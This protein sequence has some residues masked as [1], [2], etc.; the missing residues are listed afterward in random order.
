MTKRTHDASLD[1]YVLRFD[2]P[3]LR[4]HIKSLALAEHRTLNGQ[5]LHLIKA[6]LSAEGHARPSKKAQQ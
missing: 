1:K 5:L 3:G 6:G 4:Q 2:E